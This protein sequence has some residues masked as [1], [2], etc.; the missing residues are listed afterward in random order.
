MSSYTAQIH[1]SVIQR[2]DILLFLA[3][4]IFFVF[5]LLIVVYFDQNALSQEN[6]TQLIA[7][8]LLVLGS[9]TQGIFYYKGTMYSKYISRTYLSRIFPSQ[10][11]HTTAL[12]RCILKLNILKG[13]VFCNTLFL[14]VMHTKCHYKLNKR[15][16]SWRFNYAQC[17]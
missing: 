5:M 2:V 4:Q 6:A 3:A 16:E 8:L 1:C 7:P 12:G 14:N 10:K 15:Y 17:S 13:F 11:L 9:S